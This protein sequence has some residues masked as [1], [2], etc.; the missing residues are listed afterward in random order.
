M[1]PSRILKIYYISTFLIGLMMSVP[2]SQ[3]VKANELGTRGAFGLILCW[4]VL[5][6]MLLPLILDWL[7]SRYLK[8]RFVTITEIAGDN[9]RLAEVISKQCEQLHIHSLKFAVVDTA[10][11]EVISY[12]LWRSNPRLLVPG[13]LLKPENQ[14]KAIPSVQA[15][16]ARFIKH[17]DNTVIFLIFAGFQ[18]MFLVFLV[19]AMH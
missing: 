14:E 13:A 15:E 11:D 7:E 8:A 18:A 4:N 19:W 6:L 2:V 5:C 3:W 1:P 10:S 17:D 9:P 12:G 16:L